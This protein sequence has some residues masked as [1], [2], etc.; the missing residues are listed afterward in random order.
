MGE[1][2]KTL[3]LFLILP[4][5]GA[6]LVAAG[7]AWLIPGAIGI[8]IGLFV[9][10]GL[11]W[12]LAGV[13]FGYTIPSAIIMTIIVAFCIFKPEGETKQFIFS[14]V[15]RIANEYEQ[16]MDELKVEAE[17]MFGK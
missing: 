10:A 13:L 3:L 8:W 14:D 1:I 17:E 5:L 15:A 4:L 7:I 2:L 16:G 12:G 6:Y 9:G 11:L